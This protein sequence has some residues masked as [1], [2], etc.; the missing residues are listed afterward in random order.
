MKNIKEYLKSDD[1]EIRLY[2]KNGEV[3]IRYL[4]DSK[5][6]WF[7]ST[8]DD[9]GNELTY[10]NSDGDWVEYTYDD[11]GNELT[12]KNSSG[13]WRKSTYDDNSNELTYKDS[14]GVER[15]FDIEEMTIEEICKALGKTIKIT[16]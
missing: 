14:R 9:N 8:Y 5:G 3:S 16:K 11:N 1:K 6:D 7:E 13:Y 2:H 4:E 15:G 12:Y 10:K